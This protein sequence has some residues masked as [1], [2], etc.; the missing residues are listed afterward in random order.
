[1]TNGLDLGLMS[2]SRHARTC[3]TAV[4][5][6]H[7]AKPSGGFG[8]A[9]RLLPPR[10][11]PCLNA[12]PPSCPEQVRARRK[13]AIGR[14][15]SNPSWVPV[16]DRWYYMS[17]I[18]ENTIFIPLGPEPPAD[19]VSA[20][21]G[22]RLGAASPPGPSRKRE[23]DAPTARRAQAPW[24]LSRVSF[25]ALLSGTSSRAGRRRRSARDPPRS[26]PRRA[27]VRPGQGR[28]PRARPICPRQGRER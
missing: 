3:S 22:P 13:G 7:W 19:T 12:R 25:R 23:Q 8:R 16:N 4:R 20:G 5:F 15:A 9:Q 1:M 24:G 17:L 21:G 6:S 26:G 11:P 10:F 14:R 2:S 28:R 18:N 27:A